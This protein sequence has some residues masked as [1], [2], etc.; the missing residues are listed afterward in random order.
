MLREIPG[1]C[2]IEQKAGRDC[3]TLILPFV[4]FREIQG[5][6]N[7]S[8]TVKK[9]QLYLSKARDIKKKGIKIE[10][11]KIFVNYL[12]S[13]SSTSILRW[14]RSNPWMIMGQ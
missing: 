4:H 11:V 10:V 1:S 6:F 12:C 3:F 14:K 8:I 13:K 2:N 5:L 9:Y 7:N